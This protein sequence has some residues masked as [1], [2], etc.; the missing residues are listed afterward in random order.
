[1]LS[2]SR[3][4]ERESPGGCWLFVSWVFSIVACVWYMGVGFEERAGWKGF[5]TT[6]MQ[7]CK[8]LHTPS[9]CCRSQIRLLGTV[10][11]RSTTH[12]LN[13]PGVGFHSCA[14]Q[15]TAVQT[16]CGLT[17][18]DAHKYI[19]SKTYTHRDPLYCNVNLFT[20]PNP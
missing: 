1:M 19:R 4:L 15:G 16:L 12:T 14:R 5:A 20:Y 18:L 8:I 6:R 13:A 2:S 10:H 11:I 9:R 7:R 3:I 17:R